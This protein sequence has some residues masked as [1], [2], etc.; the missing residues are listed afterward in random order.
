MVMIMMGMTLMMM[1]VKILS[2]RMLWLNL[3][4]YYAGDST[5][6]RRQLA[7]TE[8]KKNLEELERN[9]TGMRS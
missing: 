9:R 8:K 5:H 2:E 7:K 1:T 4:Y 6:A 3:S